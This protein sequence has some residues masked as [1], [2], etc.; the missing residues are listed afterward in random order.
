MWILSHWLR[1]KLKWSLLTMRVFPCFCLLHDLLYAVKTGEV[2]RICN[3]DIYPILSFIK[4]LILA[5][6]LCEETKGGLWVHHVWISGQEADFMIKLSRCFVTVQW[7]KRYICS[8][9]YCSRFLNEYNLFCFIFSMNWY[10]SG[11]KINIEK[12]LRFCDFRSNS[13]AVLHFCK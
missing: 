13:T 12:A 6:I 3:A 7:P 9:R 2:S 4:P 1:T 10:D 8:H 5:V 11:T